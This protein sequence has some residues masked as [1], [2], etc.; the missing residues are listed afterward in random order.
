MYD[1]IYKIATDLEK[2]D[3]VYHVNLSIDINECIVNNEGCFQI[4]F[5]TIGSFYCSYQNG[6]MLDSDYLT[7]QGEFNIK[8]YMYDNIYK[9]AILKN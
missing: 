7:C 5:N 8:L 1:N 3:V 4:C 9:I 2:I 6:F